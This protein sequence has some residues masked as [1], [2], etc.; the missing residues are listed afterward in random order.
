MHDTPRAGKRGSR[1]AGGPSPG[2]GSGSGSEEGD[3][4]AHAVYESRLIAVSS[5]E[6]LRGERPGG[7]RRRSNSLPRRSSGGR[8][9][10]G[11][12]TVRCAWNPA[13]CTFALL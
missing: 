9:R 1:R 4:A 10:G 2:S 6:R 3:E 12:E 13:L 11:G 8:Q 5:A 7:E